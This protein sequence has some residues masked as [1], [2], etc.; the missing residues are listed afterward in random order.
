MK[1]IRRLTVAGMLWCLFAFVPVAMA[2]D[3]SIAKMNEI[4]AAG[5]AQKFW[6]V[7]ADEVDGWIKQKKTDF[8][9]VDVRPNPDEY[10]QGRIPGSVQISIQ[11]ILNPANIAK[12]PKNK[13]LVLVCV[14]GQ[15]QNLPIVILRAMGYDAYTMAFGYAA[16]IP[17]YRGGQ[18][19]QAAIQNAGAK[20]YPLV[21]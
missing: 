13:K 2:N 17:D 20:K 10:A 14:T 12:L 15:V 6:Q 19:M 11:N 5:Q 21:K 9:V 18:N 4:L 7:Q 16:W 3:L 8:V 1:M